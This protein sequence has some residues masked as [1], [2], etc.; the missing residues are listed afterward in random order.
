VAA[1]GN[2]FTQADPVEYPAALLQPLGSDGVGGSGLVVAASDL[3]GGW[4]G[5]SNTGSWISIAAPGVNVFSAL[6]AALR[7]TTFRTVRLPGSRAGSYGYGT[8]TSFAAPQVAGAAAL[9]WAANPRLKAAHVA[10][11][12]KETASGR[13]RWNP[14]LGF[15]VLDVAA[16]VARAEET[17]PVPL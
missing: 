3:G 16:A 5:F 11:I 8:G 6:P 14:Q 1:A 10:A 2:D 15:G 13:G 7:E 17:A 9:V 4:A 12:L